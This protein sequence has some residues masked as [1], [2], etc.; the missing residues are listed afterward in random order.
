MASEEYPSTSRFIGAAIVQLNGLHLAGVLGSQFEN[1]VVE[2]PGTPIFDVNGTVLFH[3]VALHRTGMSLGYVD[4]ADQPVLGEPILAIGIGSTW[5]AAEVLK[6]GRDL[7]L[8]RH[9]F[10]ADAEAHLIAYSFPKLAVEIRES[11]RESLMLEV[12]SWER[13]PERTDRG[14]GQP[15]GNFERWSMLEEIDSDVAGRNRERLQ[16]T[17]DELGAFDS[18]IERGVISASLAGSLLEPVEFTDSRELHYSPLNTD[19]F[20]CYQLR[21]Q[22]TPYWC[23][24]AS[25]EMLL[26]FYRYAYRQTHIATQLDLGTPSQPNGLPYSSVGEVVTALEALTGSALSAQMVTPGSFGLFVDELDAN[27][28]LISF[29]PGHSRAVAGYTITQGQIRSLNFQGLLVYDPWPPNTG[30]VT[31]WENY[32]ATT[33]LETYTAT[34]SLH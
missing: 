10:S 3:R 14:P 34:V 11:G 6:A 2:A 28:P 18:L 9:G 22:Q 32:N 15:P 29:I 33:Y 12:G 13:V 23:V 8:Q 21:A 4:V 20:V 31:R 19:H 5:S 25:V 24:A 30:V 26:D 1:A 16:R 17:A 7:A 27:R